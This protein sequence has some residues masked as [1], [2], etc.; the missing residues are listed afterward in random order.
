MRQSIFDIENRLDINIEFG[1]FVETLNQRD[2][3]IYDCKYMSLFSFFDNYVFH[4]WPYR[5]T[6]I[7]LKSYLE[8]IGISNSIYGGHQA[9]DEVAFLNFVELLENMML[10]VKRR[11]GFDNV[12]FLNLKTA[13]IIKH[14]IPIILEKMN[15]E[16]YQEMD[17]ICIRKRDADV[18]SILEIVPADVS[19]L[20]LS[21]N[22]IR[23]NDIESKKAIIKKLDLFIE[24]NKTTY[25]SLNSST[26]DSIQTIVNKMGIN[27]P[28]L[29]EPYK[30]FNSKTLIEWYDKC[31]KLILHLI[32]C[33]DINKINKERNQ[34]IGKE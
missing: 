6:F 29:E 21:Y 27:H 32:R 5:D 10:M 14:N 1:R 19:Q 22:D 4:I 25:K 18:D 8:H 9:I 33:D 17:K 15:Y 16:S 20:L 30:S 13:N 12:Q 31:F 11:I 34:L 23:N 7:D 24:G 28:M 3:I 2:T 26:Y